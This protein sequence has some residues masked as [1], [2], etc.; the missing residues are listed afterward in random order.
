MNTGVILPVAEAWL[1]YDGHR[2][3]KGIAPTT[4][5]AQYWLT[6]VMVPEARELLRR[7]SRDKDRDKVFAGERAAKL[8]VAPKPEDSRKAFRERDDWAKTAGPPDPATAERMRKLMGG[9]GR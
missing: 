3:G 4:K 9:L 7:E 2:A 8:G 1:R 6:T 5:D